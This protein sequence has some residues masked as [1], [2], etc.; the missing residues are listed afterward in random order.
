MEHVRIS[1]DKKDQLKMELIACNLEVAGI[2]NKRIKTSEFGSA[3]WIQALNKDIRH[4][5]AVILIFSESVHNSPYIKAEI[6]YANKNNISIFLMNFT[7]Q[8][9]S[10]Q[11]AKNIDV[12]D[13][14]SREQHHAG[15]YKLVNKLYPMMNLTRYQKIYEILYQVV[16]QIPNIKWIHLISADSYRLVGISGLFY[17]TNNN[18]S[19]DIHFN[20]KED[21]IA[22]L[23][24]APFS[25]MERVVENLSL[26]QARFSI[27]SGTTAMNLIMIVGSKYEY[28]LTMYIE[29]HPSLDMVMNYFADRDYLAEIEDVWK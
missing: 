17:D 3:K 10:S 12:I 7:N 8:P 26:G 22:P 16:K 4:C 28:V 21:L 1:Y 2:R 6:E 9:I 19:P 24:A 15:I 23:A 18:I 5:L 29:G 25:I 13:F 14:A 27:I 11:P 20:T